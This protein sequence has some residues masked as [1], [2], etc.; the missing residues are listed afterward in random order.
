MEHNPGREK[1]EEIYQV[2]ACQK[3]C[4]AVKHFYLL[5]KLQMYHEN[6]ESLKVYYIIFLWPSRPVYK[7]ILRQ[8]YNLAVF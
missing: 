8:R 2:T 5:A 1:K 4:L 3:A 7:E 6:V